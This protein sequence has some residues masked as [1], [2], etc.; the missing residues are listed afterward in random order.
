MDTKAWEELLGIAAPWRV[1]SMEVDVERQ[2]VVVR[3]E[4]GFRS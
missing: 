1:A 3:I 2:E 4:P